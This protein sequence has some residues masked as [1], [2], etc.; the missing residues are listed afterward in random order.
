MEY[1]TLA[2]LKEYLG[3]VD[4]ASDVILAKVIKRCTQQFDKYL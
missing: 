3:I 4:T 1:T 2:T